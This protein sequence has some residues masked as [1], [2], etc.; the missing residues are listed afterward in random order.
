MARKGKDKAP[1]AIV[2]L[3]QGGKISP[4]SQYDED[5]MRK[6]A[7]GTEFDLV[8]RTARSIP[9]HG[10]YWKTLTLV[11]DATGRWRNRNALH[12]ALKIKLGRIEPVFDLQGGIVGYKPDSTSFDSMPHRDFC[13]FMDEALAELADAI[14]YDPLHW[15]KK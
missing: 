11:V 10:T 12:D 15:M 4:V 8:P 3:D 2:S 9:Q 5:E 7:L 14:G 6:H 13:E 1:P